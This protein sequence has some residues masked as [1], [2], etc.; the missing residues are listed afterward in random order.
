MPAVQQY[1]PNPVR[2]LVGKPSNRLSATGVKR[3][4]SSAN[5]PGMHLQLHPGDTGDY[6]LVTGRITAVF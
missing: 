4:S 3:N 2:R 6:Y 5:H 1:K